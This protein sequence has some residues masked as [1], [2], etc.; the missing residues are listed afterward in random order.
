MSV[1]ITQTVWDVTSFQFLLDFLCSIW[2]G[3]SQLFYQLFKLVS[4]V[5]ELGR[6]FLNRV[7]PNQCA[8]ISFVLKKNLSKLASQRLNR[9]CAYFQNSK[10]M[11]SDAIL[12]EKLLH[13]IQL[14]RSFCF[15]PIEVIPHVDVG[16]QDTPTLFALGNP[17]GQSPYPV[18]HKKGV[19]LDV[20]LQDCTL[21]ALPVK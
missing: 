14:V 5:S 1:V 16:S 2:L 6:P 9:P 21:L 15:D 19:D 12:F 4:L 10:T 7:N 17:L 18:E 11:L 20:R 13:S 3:N 8:S